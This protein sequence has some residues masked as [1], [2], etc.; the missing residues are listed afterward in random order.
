MSF[1]ASF[2]PE[3]LSAFSAIILIGASFFTSGL[4][5]AAGVGGG[6]LM[7]A[8]MTYLIPITALIPVHGL[9]QL[10]SNAGRTWVQ[11]VNVDWNIA[12]YF[13]LGSAIGALAG[14]LLAVKLPQN[15]LEISLG[16]FILVLIWVKFPP[17]RNAGNPI[18]SLGGGVTTFISMF[19]GATGPLVAVFLNKLFTEHRHLVATHGATMTAQ[20]ALK[21]TA[22]GFVGFAFGQWLP[23]VGAMVFSG[24][25]GTKAG[26]LLMNRLPEKQLKQLF[27][28]T[29]TLVALDLMRRGFGLF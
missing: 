4:T 28:W 3:G 22:F 14:A 8:L 25:L 13:L 12:R 5:A 17:I 16:V 18:I 7:L 15:L 26:T 24:Y 1:G 29:L 9:V 27:K 20:H 11:R 10:G 2:L 21:V 19:A 23:L 6:L